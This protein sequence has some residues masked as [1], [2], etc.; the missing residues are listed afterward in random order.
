MVE[1]SV[2][3]TDLLNSGSPL[4]HTR[5]WF[6]LVGEEAGEVMEGLLWVE[7][8]RVAAAHLPLPPV[9]QHSLYRSDPA[10]DR[11]RQAAT[12]QGE[13]ARA[14]AWWHEQGL[15]TLQQGEVARA[16][17]LP[18]ASLPPLVN[19]DSAL[20]QARRARKQGQLESLALA[21][22]E[23]ARPGN[24]L[25]D[26]CAGGGHL[27]LLLAHLLPDSTVHMVENKEE[28]LARARARGLAMERP[29]SWFFQSNLDY[30]RGRFAV[31]ASLH[32]CGLATDLVLRQCT[33]AGAA[34][35][36]CPC[37]YG[38]VAATEGLTYPR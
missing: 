27:G 28:S 4:P 12:S 10:R 6:L 2:P 37:C 31:G 5:R 22:V 8:G 19:P 30:Y 9:P 20:P 33:A 26:F 16:Q 17:G 13:V 34:F 38:G 23:L 24:T 29:N 25:V 3:R 15:D 7:E 21:L 14:L 32:A 1:A 11:G 35:V 36:C 18:W